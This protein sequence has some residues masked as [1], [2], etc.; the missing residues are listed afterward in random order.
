MENVKGL[1][2]VDQRALLWFIMQEHSQTG[3]LVVMFKQ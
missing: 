2:A 1:L 3:Q